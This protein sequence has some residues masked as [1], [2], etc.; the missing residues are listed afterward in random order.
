MLRDDVLIGDIVIYHREVRPFTD[1]QIELLHF[2]AQAVVAI[3]T[4]TY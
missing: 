4:Q 2:A 3:E 1:K